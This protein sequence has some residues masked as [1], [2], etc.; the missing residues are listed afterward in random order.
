MKVKSLTLQNFRNIDEMNLNFHD[1]VNL[2]YGENAQG[3]T[4]VIE[5]ISL[6]MQKKSFRT[7]HD[8]DLIKIGEESA[9]IGVV[10]ETSI[11]ENKGEIVFSK[12][13]RTATL[14][15]L[16]L[17]DALKLNEDFSRVVFSPTHLSLIKD[18][19]ETRRR[20]LD[21]CISAVSPNYK[22]AMVLFNRILFQRNSFLKNYDAQKIMDS[23]QI[24]TFLNSWNELMAQYGAYI[25]FMR[26]KYLKEFNKQA[27][28]I[29]LGISDNRED[30]E[31]KYISTVFDDENLENDD[32][33]FITKFYEDALLNDCEEDLKVGYTQKGIQRDDI[34]ILINGISAKNYGS[35]G[36]QRSA[37]LALKL[38]ECEILNNALGEYPVILLD[39]VMSELDLKRKQ[40]IL[41]KVKNT[42]V[43]ITACDL[44]EDELNLGGK[45]FHIQNGKVI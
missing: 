6:C 27:K 30:F 25:H 40:F 22:N 16:N 14:N 13:K 41:Q 24:R 3:K 35:Q 39:D 38:A 5:A 45:I 28:K 32:L 23:W 37:V 20:F 43:F 1:G 12:G 17:K 19:P 10:Y 31:I 29:Y 33:K 2:I 9:K 15:G 34:E 11:R 44:T 36:Q 8:R 7:S 21:E 4:N 18:A 42:Q 26:Q